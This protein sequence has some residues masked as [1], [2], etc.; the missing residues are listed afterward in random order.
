MYHLKRKALILPLVLQIKKNIV[1]VN[2]KINSDSS[3]SDTNS[4]LEL[5]LLKGK[6]K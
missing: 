5:V 1:I 4:K 2:T 6:P 3:C